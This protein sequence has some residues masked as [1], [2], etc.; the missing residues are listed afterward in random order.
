M[1]PLRT[2]LVVLAAMSTATLAQAQ[3]DRTGTGS[4]PL[5]TQRAPN[6]TA[7]GRTKPPS[8]AASPA[9]TGTVK[10]RTRIERQDDAISRG[11]CVGCD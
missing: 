3:T 1:L 8:R 4:G 6:T 5:S 2:A 9:T 7:V 10:H 11:I